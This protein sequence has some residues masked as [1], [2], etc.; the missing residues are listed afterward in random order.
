MKHDLR[1][2]LVVA[3]PFGAVAVWALVKE[4]KRRGLRRFC[5]VLGV[6]LIGF[7]LLGLNIWLNP[8]SQ[9]PEPSSNIAGTENEQSK[10]QL[11]NIPDLHKLF[12]NDFSTLMRVTT[13]RM[14]EISLN[15]ET[16]TPSFIN[17]GQGNIITRGPPP[18]PHLLFDIRIKKALPLN[19]QR[20]G[21][22]VTKVTLYEQE[23]QDY[24]SKS[25]FIGY[26]ISA[27]PYAY[28][29]C[30]FLSTFYKITMDDFDSIA[31]IRFGRSTESTLT[32]SSELAFTGRVYIYYEGIFT[33]QELAAI[34]RLYQCKGL[35]V[36][37]RGSAYLQSMWGKEK[38]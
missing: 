1:W 10:P 13:D 7:S 22:G 20:S 18:S 32:S 15:N 2:L 31:E 28:N 8:N 14:I 38:K 35:S 33:L 24:Q 23:Y 5:F 37:L 27:S 25:K 3:W 16:G 26:Y 6:I 21:P 34:E 19:T 4:V 30:E 9:N 36:V 17:E 29:I 12:D 11:P